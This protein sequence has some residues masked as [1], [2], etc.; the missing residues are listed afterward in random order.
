MLVRHSRILAVLALLFVGSEAVAQGPVL[1]GAGPVNR[2]MGGASTAAPLDATGT[3]YWNPA[4]ISGLKS[5]QLDLGLEI[6]YPHSAVRS[7]IPA[8][9]LD[10]KT[11]DEAGVF[12][13]PT[14]GFVFKP[15]D[16]GWTF[17]LGI[18]PSSGFGTN[19]PGST[20]NP[21]LTPPPPA[22]VGLGSVASNYQVLQIAPTVAYQV[23]ERLSI[24]FAPLINLGKLSVTPGVF[25]SPDDANGD[26]A[27]HYPTATNTRFA[28]GAGFQ[29][30]VYFVASE[31]WAFGAAFK[32]PQWFEPYRYNVSDELGRARTVQLQFDSPLIV[33]LGTAY[34]GIDK[35]TL[36]CDVRY[37]NFQNTAGFRHAGFNAS[38]ATTGL[39]W[40]DV[41]SASLG[42]Q[43]QLTEKIAMRLGYTYNTNPIPPENATFNV[44]SPLTYQHQIGTGASYAL[45]PCCTLSAAYYH[46]FYQTVTGPYLTPGGAVPGASVSVGAG[47]DSLIAGL[48]VKF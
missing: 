37:L 40:N 44:A 29:A 48:S 41:F 46:I 18:F 7:A 27:P 11:R 45:T 13:L 12:P 36:A 24:G 31:D 15:A 30:G 33:S 42:S 38:G 16:S 21:I 14:G 3:L 5:S 22:G 34:T 9:G 47:A 17:G 43:Y 39:G 23:T 10:G 25:V 28:W 1:S 2:S 6:L 35:L 19:F 4:A 20:S 26:G 8:A 32:S